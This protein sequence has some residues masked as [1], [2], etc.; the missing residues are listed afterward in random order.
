MLWDGL[1]GAD[2]APVIAE[3]N[4]AARNPRSSAGYSVVLWHAWSK[5][6]DN[7]MSV[8]NGLAPHVKI[9]P[10]DSLVKMVGTYAKQ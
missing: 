9:I 5:S 6:V 4:S 7:V 3:R 2:E 10:P 8:V 1:D